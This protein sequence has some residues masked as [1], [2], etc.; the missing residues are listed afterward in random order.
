MPDP[1]GGLSN[2]AEASHR[3]NFYEL[4]LIVSRQRG[5]DSR[6]AAHSKCHG[7]TGAILRR[8]NSNP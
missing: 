8:T 4:A 3:Q 7:K 1:G 2:A 6:I 5:F